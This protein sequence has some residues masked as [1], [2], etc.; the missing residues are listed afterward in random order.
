MVDLRY[1]FVI[2]N[3]S[4]QK[5]IDLLNKVVLNHSVET[6][7]QMRINLWIPDNY[8]QFSS[9]MVADDKKFLH[10]RTQPEKN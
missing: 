9:F 4:L 1:E 6:W 3:S 5:L 7:Y 2:R 10:L 8:N